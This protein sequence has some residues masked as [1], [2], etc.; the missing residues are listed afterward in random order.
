MNAVGVR[1]RNE[2]LRPCCALFGKVFLL[3]SGV[4]NGTFKNQHSI[5]EAIGRHLDLFEM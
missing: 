2:V 4:I 5:N 1:L 3:A